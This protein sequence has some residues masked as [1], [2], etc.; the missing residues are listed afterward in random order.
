MMT[1]SVPST[2]AA[3]NYPLGFLSIANFLEQ[4]GFSVGIRNL[5]LVN[6]FFPRMRPERLL[7]ILR[8]RVFGIDLH[9]ATNTDGALELARTLKRAYP[10]SK[11]VL[12]GLTASFF[13]RELLEFPYIDFVIR[14]DCAEYPLLFLLEVTTRSRVVLPG[15]LRRVPNL[16]WKNSRGDIC[17]NGI[18]YV[19]ESLDEFPT[20]Y[21]WVFRSAAR[22]RDPFGLILSLPFRDWLKNP[23]A[24]VITQ[25]G[26]PHNCVMCGG[27]ASAYREICGRKRSAIKSPPAV[28]RDA[29]SAAN[30]IHG[31]IFLMGDLRDPSDSYAEEVFR[32]WKGAGIENPLLVEAM[33]PAGADFFERAVSCAREVSFQI[34]AET[35]D[36]ALRKR[37]GRNY[38]SVQ[39]EETISAAL[40]AGCKT[41]R[42]FFGIGLPGQD[43]KSVMETVSYCAELLERFGRDRRLHPFI[44]PLLPFIEPGSEVFA[45]PQKFGYQVFAKSVSDYCRAMRARAWAETLG[46]ETDAMERETLVDVSYEAAIK[47]NALYERFGLISRKGGKREH[48]RLKREWEM[49]KGAKV[50]TRHRVVLPLINPLAFRYSGILREIIRGLGPPRRR[51]GSRAAVAQPLSVKRLRRCGG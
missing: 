40:E 45:D 21:G 18:S 8:A 23:Q 30:I 24:A 42:V 32:L 15:D 37:F 6:S 46:Y 2:P 51:S 49:V 1:A 50:T 13:W 22:R 43:R 25:K 19:P 10:H 27:S 35:H 7:G 9:W 12:G 44:S 29:V 28:V 5:A 31:T 33:S 11:T 47:M 39:L 41:V 20:D 16:A 36:D 17:D 14:G 26:C 4:H 38:T 34:S 3:E 48:E